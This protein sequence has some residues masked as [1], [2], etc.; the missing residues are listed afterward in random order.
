MPQ[1]SLSIQ[2]RCGCGCRRWLAS[3]LGGEGD[4]HSSKSVGVPLDFDED[5]GDCLRRGPGGRGLQPAPLGA[6][7]GGEGGSS[8]TRSSRECIRECT[9]KGSTRPSSGPEPEVPEVSPGPSERPLAAWAPLAT[10]PPPPHPVSWSGLASPLSTAWAVGTGAERGGRRYL[11]GSASTSKAAKSDCAQLFDTASLRKS[12]HCS[13]CSF[14]SIATVVNSSSGGGESAGMSATARA[15]RSAQLLRTSEKRAEKS[16][17]ELTPA[18]APVGNSAPD[19]PEVPVS[20]LMTPLTRP[21]VIADEALCGGGAGV[22]LV[23]WARLCGVLPHVQ[24]GP[25]PTKPTAGRVAPPDD[26]TRRSAAASA[27]VRKPAEASDVWPAAAVDHGGAGGQLAAAG[28]TSGGAVS[29]GMDWLPRL[30]VVLGF[31]TPALVGLPVSDA[32]PPP[33]PALRFGVTGATSGATGGATADTEVGFAAA[34]ERML[35]G[36][37]SSNSPSPSR[38]HT[39]AGREPV[40]CAPPREA[41]APA[42]AARRASRST[43]PSAP[44]PWE[45]ALTTPATPSCRRPTGAGAPLLL[46][47]LPPPPPAA[48]RAA[49]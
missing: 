24:N 9:G 30:R 36:S 25:R 49:A 34:R 46:L 6:T 43:A 37:G 22:P 29:L 4:S 21:R 28:A 47:L 39:A 1:V 42:A 5:V 27:P 16:P 3:C 44:L 17:P 18:T 45:V 10:E 20:E 11:G 38:S 19:E 12:R 7:R 23:L 35:S 13:R 8:G 14:V 48:A 31:P 2:R 41:S 32:W 40:A 15:R 26:G 33:R